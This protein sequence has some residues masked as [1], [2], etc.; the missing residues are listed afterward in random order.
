MKCRRNKN[1]SGS[2]LRVDSAR[3]TRPIPVT[4]EIGG[5]AAVRKGPGSER[6]GS[7]PVLRIDGHIER[8]IHHSGTVAV[9]P[10]AHLVGDI[11]ASV[12]FVEGAI[13]GNVRATESLHIAASATI[14]GDLHT[15]RVA[16]A[17]GAQLRGN[18]TMRP[19]LTP[20]SDLDALAVDTL[21]AG[22]RRA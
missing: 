12:V 19:S 16:V 14:V 13:S 4:G 3:G 9:G 20:P 22:G 21:L 15:P 5:P 6:E 7:A 10:H 2:R 1:S 17:R 11:H 18:I 8:S